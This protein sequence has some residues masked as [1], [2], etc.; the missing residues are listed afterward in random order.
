ML[1]AVSDYDDAL[2]E[3]FLNDEPVMEAD[4]IRALRMAVINCSVCPTLL[5]SALK[6]KGIHRL[7]DAVTDYLPSP[8]DLPPVKGYSS[9][10][11]KQL[12]RKPDLNEP[13]SALCFKVAT[14]PH[15][16]RLSYVRIYSGEIK[17]GNYLLNP[18]SGIKERVGRILEMHSN[19]RADVPSASAGDIVAIIG[20]RKTSTGDTLCNP[21]NPIILEHMRF[22]EPVIFVAIEPKSQADQ[23]KLNESMLKLEEEDPTFKVKYNEETGQT[24]ISGMGELHLE[25]LVERLIRE[26]K[27]HAN[28]GKPSV[29]YKE[30]ITEEVEV[31]GK[32]IRQSGGKGQYGYVKIF[33]QPATNGTVFAF[34]NRLKGSVIPREFIPAIEK[35]L[36]NAM[37]NG[38][39]AGYPM[40]SI[41]TA[42]IDASYHN[43][44]SSEMAFEIAASMALKNG[45][46][47]GNPIVLEPI[48]E[49]EV[50]C[51][52]DYMG[53]IVGDLNLRRG[54]IGGMVP[55]SNKQVITAMIPLAEMFGYATILRN[56]TQGRGA[57]TM[58]FSKYAPL[59]EEVSG[60]MFAN[61]MFG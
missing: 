45:A 60:K 11:K 19:K 49:V 55:R 48:M 9:D 27:V 31:E 28:V 38:V 14:C 35:G 25:I 50:V 13:A 59:P 12:E 20:F 22:P 26:F 51:P 23:D 2:L 30:T 47:K 57:Y 42:L 44:D 21:K 61:S 56:L 43:V 6:N 10:G 54:K 18:I 5:G 16:G 40:T 46:K 58:Q 39:I 34:E 8:T 1:E 53:N 52:E 7:L 29:A 41:K 17:T 24:I 33:M 37:S 36:K 4:I 3:K 32:F 15:S